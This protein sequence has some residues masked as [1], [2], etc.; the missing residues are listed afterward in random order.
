[1]INLIELFDAS[2]MGIVGL[3]IGWATI[4]ALYVRLVSLTKE[5][6]E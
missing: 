5:T 4:A 6:N 2:T 1:M 3:L